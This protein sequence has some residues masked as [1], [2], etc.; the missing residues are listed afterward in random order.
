MSRIR[1]IVKKNIKEETLW[2]LAVEQDESYIANGVVVHN[3]RSVL[4]PITKFEDWSADE[5]TNSGQD[6]DKFLKENVQDAGF[7]IYQKEEKPVEIPMPEITDPGV[8]FKTEFNGNTESI[9][10]FLKDRHFQ[11]TIIVYQDDT[12]QRILSTEHLKI[13]A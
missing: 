13:N 10:Y 12:R 6:V 5:V 11:T 1:S 9:K 8:S 4:I 7:S 3:C 2:N